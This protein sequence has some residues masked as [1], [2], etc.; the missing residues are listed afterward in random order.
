MAENGPSGL[1][2]SVSPEQSPAIVGVM[3]MMCTG[4]SEFGLLA[5]VR[6]RYLY[7]QYGNTERSQLMTDACPTSPEES[8]MVEAPHLAQSILSRV[9]EKTLPRSNSS[10]WL[11]LRHSTSNPVQGTICLLSWFCLGFFVCLE[12]L[13]R[14]PH[15]K[16][17]IPGMR[18]IKRFIWAKPSMKL[19]LTSPCSVPLS[20]TQGT[21]LEAWKSSS[22]HHIYMSPSWH[23]PPDPK[24]FLVLPNSHPLLRF[25]PQPDLCCSITGTVWWAAKSSNKG[26]INFPPQPGI[27][28]KD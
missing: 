10:P 27:I 3:P 22:V 21:K 25:A 20:P 12:F 23:A 1:F 7:L 6:Q 16:M 28:P 5:S 2:R 24:H 14:L 17:D 4:N 8:L 13:D 11:C 18:F 15:L 19:L 9:L 26:L